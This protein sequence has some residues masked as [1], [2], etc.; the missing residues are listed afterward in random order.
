M[1]GVIAH[2]CS[3]RIGAAAADDHDAAI[4]Q[5]GAVQMRPS[6]LFSD[7]TFTEFDMKL[8]A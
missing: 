3:F 7:R 4:A 5:V 6:R 1:G 8:K 2:W